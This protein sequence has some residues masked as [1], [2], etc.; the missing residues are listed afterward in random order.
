MHKWAMV[1]LAYQAGVIF[2]LFIAFFPYCLYGAPEYMCLSSPFY[3]A[4][5]I[6][7][8]LLP[9][10]PLMPWASKFISALFSGKH[11][12]FSKGRHKWDTDA[13]KA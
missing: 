11:V 5:F 9:V 12:A 4:P 3:A 2:G 1:D 10:L 8:F 6:T 7:V 13:K